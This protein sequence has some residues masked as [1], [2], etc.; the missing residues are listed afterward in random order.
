MKKNKHRL[1]GILTA[2]ILALP[3][4]HALA[5]DYATTTTGDWASTNTWGG[6]G[7]PS[8]AADT[9]L[10]QHGIAYGYIGAVLATTNLGTAGDYAT[11][12]VATNGWVSAID[13]TDVAT[14]IANPVI[15]DGGRLGSG[16]W[17][18]PGGE[19]TG[20]IT[21]TTNGLI[22]APGRWGSP[23]LS[24]KVSGP[25]GITLT[26]PDVLGS[27][28]LTLNNPS[29]DFAGNVV[30]TQGWLTLACDHALPTGKVVDVYSDGRLH[31]DVS[32][33]YASEP[34]PIV[35]LYGGG[36]V[37]GTEG[38]PNLT[39]ALAYNVSAAG[40]TF[41]SGGAS[42]ASGRRVTG[43]IT[44]A[45]GG[46][47]N[48][49]GNR[50]GGWTLDGPVSG[51]GVLRFYVFDSYGNGFGGS[52]ITG[53]SNTHSGGT[54]VATFGAA[55][56]HTTIARG[57]GSLGTGPVTVETNTVMA[58]DKTVNADWTLT[59]TLAGAGT[60]KVEDGAGT[61]TLMVLG[62]VDPGMNSVS[63]VTNM[64]GVLRVDGDLAFG[65]GSRLK[66]DIT[67]TNGVAGVDYDRLVVDHDLTGLGNAVL[68]I[69][70]STNLVKVT[71]TG[72]ELVVVSNAAS[73]AV[74]QFL[75]VQWNDPWRGKVQYN[76]PPGTVKLIDVTSAPPS[77]LVLIVR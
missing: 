16:R 68:E 20:P 5:T 33:T 43:P 2:A 6:S 14:T 61:N 77:G 59:N 72:Q 23:K 3:A 22:S 45:S 17:H 48:I 63:G 30:V 65:A 19:W 46:T 39:K 37:M 28:G 27:G 34:P 51:A 12:T 54:I 7:P 11:I 73:V 25:G 52:E 50:G 64:A 60:F 67:G 66:I 15:F 1:T 31:C 74:D 21:I 53:T 58:L 9:G 75:D 69:G 24:G 71:L 44:I 76:D 42:W 70:G 26:T 56:T 38:Y 49:G 18:S 40:G 10:I 29:N 41:N 47:L 13:A 4:S 57:E 35:N 36:L 32:Q 62:T 55:A 8:S